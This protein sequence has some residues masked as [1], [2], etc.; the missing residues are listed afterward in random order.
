[1]KKI[2]GIMA[3]VLLLS[4]IVIAQHRG[5]MLPLTDKACREIE[6]MLV[7]KGYDVVVLDGTIG[8]NLTS[9]EHLT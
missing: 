3:V 7:S 1:M 4:S 8:L 9:Q 6:M 2:L 5:A